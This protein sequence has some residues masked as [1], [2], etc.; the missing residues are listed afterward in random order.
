MVHLRV[1][2]F[3]FYYGLTHFQSSKYMVLSFHLS[4]FPFCWGQIYIFMFSSLQNNLSS[5]LKMVFHCLLLLIL[6]FYFSI[7][8]KYPLGLFPMH[9]DLY[10]LVIVFHHYEHVLVAEKQSH[11]V[12][13]NDYFGNSFRLNLGRLSLATTLNRQPSFYGHYSLMGCT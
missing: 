4:V 3:T 6:Q 2:T 9:C 1:L 12:Y 5:F 11:Q 8:R 10:I 7:T 13:S